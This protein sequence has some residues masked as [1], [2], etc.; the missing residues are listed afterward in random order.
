MAIVAVHE[1]LFL[2][3]PLEISYLLPLLF[4]IVPLW[5]LALRPGRGVLFLVLAATIGYG[6]A[7]KLDVL[8]VHYNKAGNVAITADIGLYIRPGVVT[9][10]IRERSESEKFYFR[11]YRLGPRH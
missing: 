10:D 2:K 8:D 5:T 6:F 3:I 9:R 11:E 1:L 7:C 4:V